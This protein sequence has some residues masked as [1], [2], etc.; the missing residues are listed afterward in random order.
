MDQGVKIG[1]VGGGQLGRMLALAGYPLGLSFTVLDPAADA[2]AGQVARHLAGEFSDTAV[3]ARL[4]SAAD[5]VT[6]EFE[7]V[8]VAAMKTLAGHLPVYPS[9][10][11]LEVLQDRLS[12]KQLFQALDMPIA[13]IVT[14]DT[15]DELLAALEVTGCPAVLKTRRMGYDGRGQYV[16]RT[17]QDV[18][19]AWQMLGGRPLL[20]EGYVDFRR[21]VSLIAARSISGATVTYPLTENTHRDGIL[22]TSCV[23]REPALQALAERHMRA[24]MRRLDYVGVLALELFEK[25]GVLIANEAAPRVHNSGHWSIEGAATSQFENHL[26][27]IL[28]WPLGSTDARG[29]CAMV[30]LIGRLPDCRSLLE[31]PGVHVHCYGKAAA[32]GRKLGHVTIVADNDVAGNDLLAAVSRIAR[33]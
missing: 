15:R 10:D 32:R 1:I 7:N 20:L 18:D 33:G 12:E 28:D 3:L 5:V 23:I 8:P 6:F 24:L 11:A 21:E 26:R 16:L 19:S 31:L 13:P 9:A 30:N 27:A 2:C 25:D 14:I 4:A 22:S 29:Y 17:P